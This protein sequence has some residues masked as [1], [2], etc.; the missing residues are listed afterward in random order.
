MYE[1]IHH[2]QIKQILWIYICI[3]FLKHLK[4]KIK[5]AFNYNSCVLSSVWIFCSLWNNNNFLIKY[6]YSNTIR[7]KK[8]ISEKMLNYETSQ[9]LK[10]S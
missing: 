3:C 8:T 4:N 1:N 9:S 6:I 5:N 2:I 7:L 10:N